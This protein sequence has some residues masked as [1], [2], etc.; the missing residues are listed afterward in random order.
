MSSKQTPFVF[1]VQ[2]N[3]Q[4]GSLYRKYTKDTLQM[5]F[6]VSPSAA[7]FELIIV[8]EGLVFM[9]IRSHYMVTNQQSEYNVFLSDRNESTFYSAIQKICTLGIIGK[10]LHIRLENFRKLRNE[11]AHDLFQIKSVFTKKAPQF[12]KDSYEQSLKN[13]FNTGLEI[14]TEFGEIVTPGK[15]TQKEY[16]KRFSGAYKREA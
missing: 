3:N 14:F 2:I 8:I 12:K 9:A 5:L 16:M 11:V 10:N 15:P 13:L 7:N 1:T 6:A 4:D